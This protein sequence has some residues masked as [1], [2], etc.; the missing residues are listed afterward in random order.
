MVYFQNRFL[1][2]LN[3]SEVAMRLYNYYV[4]IFSPLYGI[5]SPIFLVLSP[6]I[7]LKFYFKTPITFD[8]YFKLIKVAFTG[9][10]NL[11]SLNMKDLGNSSPLTITKYNFNSN[12]DYFLYI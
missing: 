10:S 12:M 9:F 7:F 11:F 4:I 3:K 6:Y 2:W 1:K 5:L 8:T